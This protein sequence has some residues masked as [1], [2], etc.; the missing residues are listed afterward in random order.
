VQTLYSVL[1]NT[2]YK[3]RSGYPKLLEVHPGGGTCPNGSDCIPAPAALGTGIAA[4]KLAEQKITGVGTDFGTVDAVTALDQS[5]WDNYNGWY[6]DLPG[7]GERQLKPLEFYDGSNI[8]TV[9]SQV[10]A[11]GTNE[12]ADANVETCN[13]TSVTNEVQ[14]RTFIN[15]M[16][17]KRPSVQIVDMN[18]DGA[19]NATDAGVSRRKVMRG[20]HNLI[21]KSRTTT[22]DVD[23][24]GNKETLARMPEQALRPSWRQLK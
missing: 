18:G 17:G 14:F 23:K 20:S 24:D 11:K 4:A 1:D 13:V 12:N 10:P 21:N 5:T 22:E 6:M 19:F 7:T 9:Y 8:L 15:I 2:R 16:D 3:A